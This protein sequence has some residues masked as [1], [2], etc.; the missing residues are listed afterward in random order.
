MAAPKTVNFTMC[1]K[2]CEQ[3]APVTPGQKERRPWVWEYFVEL[4]CADCYHRLKFQEKQTG[5]K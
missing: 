2:S 1:S 4:C 3:Y 5:Q